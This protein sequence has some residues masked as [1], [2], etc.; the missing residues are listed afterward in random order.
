M[1]KR[2]FSIVY[3]FLLTLAFTSLVTVVKVLS[4]DRIEA[5]QRVKLE[6]IVLKVLDVPV[7]ADTSDEKLSEIF[8]DRVKA[9]Q[10]K[11][12]TLYVHYGKNGR[13]ILG[14]AFPVG[15]PGFWGPVYGMAAV[16]P[17]ADRILGLAFYRHSE[18]PGL[19]ARM[20]E[21]WFTQQFSGLPLYPVT[22]RKKIFYLKPEGT[23]TNPNE[24]DAITGATNTSAA[25]E[26]FLNRDLDQF[27][28]EIWDSVRK[29]AEKDA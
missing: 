10:V 9:I 20:T 22:G 19:G 14:Y 6:R 24:L 12:K 26:T 7:P 1:K 29:K 13:N 27:L 3:M 25:I 4:E 21:D 17:Q 15:G 23:G 18:T 5:N 16:G 8:K 28:R 2:L 11:D